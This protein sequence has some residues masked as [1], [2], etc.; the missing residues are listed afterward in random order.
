MMGRHFD[1]TV[2][3]HNI[4]FQNWSTTTTKGVVL[5]SFLAFLFTVLFEGLKSLKSYVVLQRKQNPYANKELVARRRVQISD[6]QTDL[7]SSSLMNQLNR[8]RLTK[9]RRIMF[10]V[11]SALN[12]VSFFYGYLLMLLVMTYS[13]WLVL[14]VLLGTGV[15]YFFFHPINEHLMMKLS[16]RPTSFYSSD[17]NSVL[18]SQHGGVF[19]FNRTEHTVSHCEC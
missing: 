17:T 3:L 2:S 11:E 15:G 9:W 14:A 4:L 18:V 8:L 10:T 19:P 6:S 7:L 1:T 5:A 16:P 13:V 12:L